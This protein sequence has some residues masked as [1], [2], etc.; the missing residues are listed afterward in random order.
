MVL[1]VVVG[2]LVTSLLQA[3]YYIKYFVTYGCTSS[4][5]TTI[6]LFCN[7][8]LSFLY[9]I[10][11]LYTINERLGNII[12]IWLSDKWAK[13]RRQ[14][15]T[16]GADIIQLEYIQTV[17]GSFDRQ[18]PPYGGESHIHNNHCAHWLGWWSKDNSGNE[19][20]PQ[21]NNG[22]Q[23]GERRSRTQ[24]FKRR[25]HNTQD[26]D[27]RP[28][29]SNGSLKEERRLHMN[30]ATLGG[31]MRSH[32]KYGSRE[33]GRRSLDRYSEPKHKWRLY[34]K[35]D[36]RDGIRRSR[37]KGNR[38]MEKGFTDTSSKT[39]SL[40]NQFKVDYIIFL[41]ERCNSRDRK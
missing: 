4:C 36:A 3:I 23:T 20:Q 19:R 29:G 34:D 14:R 27:R 38:Y 28:H 13:C 10:S 24:H 32:N 40:F 1:L 17:S 35:N 37:D 21:S 7:G 30:Y 25:L 2:L 16:S 5:S 41:N 18:P 9:S 6:Y 31:E 8:I 15:Y 33:F 11:V 39:L 12:R 26:R 22:L